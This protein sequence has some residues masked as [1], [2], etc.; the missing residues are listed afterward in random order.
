MVTNPLFCARVLRR[1][2]TPRLQAD[3]D[4]D[5]LVGA[6]SPTGWRRLQ[7]ILSNKPAIRPSEEGQAAH[8]G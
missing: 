3:P 2:P 6:D 1:V 5:S 4:N 7:P 8:P